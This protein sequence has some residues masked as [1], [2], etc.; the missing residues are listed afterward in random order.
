MGDFTQVTLGT[1]TLELGGSDA[2]FLKG[3]VKFT[4]TLDSK[5]FESGVPLMLEGKVAI[6]EKVAVETPLAQL[7]IGNLAKAAATITIH[8]EAG[9]PVTV[10]DGANQEKVFAAY[11]GGGLQAIVLD[12]PDVTSLVVKNT[13]EST[14]YTAGVDYLLDDD[15]GIVWR[16]P[17]GAIT[18]GQTV[19]VAYGYTPSAYK[20][21]RFGKT[22]TFVATSVK[23]EHT[24]PVSGKVDEI[25]LPKAYGS[26]N[27]ELTYK[28]EDFLISNVRFDAVPDRVNFP[29]YPLGY[30]RRYD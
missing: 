17:T 8:T 22:F 15:L 26:G 10:A 1:G 13:A 21:L 6:R 19:R 18:A 7:S 25:F 2:G 16:I 5:D 11:G 29:N 12:G 27:L 9:T 4:R 23:F 14:T 30:H 28:E 3:D 24:S 20:E